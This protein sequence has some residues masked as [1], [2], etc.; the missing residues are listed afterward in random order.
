MALAETP[1]GA[2]NGVNAVFTLAEIPA[3][4]M[5]FVDRV[6]QVQSTDYSLAGN[7][8]TFAAGAI[9]QLN[10]ILVW[11]TLGSSSVVPTVGGTFVSAGEIINDAAIELGL[12]GGNITDPYSSSDQNIVLLCRLLK[13]CGRELARQHQW[14]WMQRT[15]E[16]TSVQNQST[17]PLPSDFRMMLN[18]TGWNRTNRLPL[19]GP[20]SPQEWEFLKARLAGVVFTVLFRPLNQTIVLYPDINTPGGYDIAFEYQSNAW[21]SPAGG[22]GPTQTNALLYTDIVYF[23]PNLAMLRLKAAFLEA[24]GFE[25][26]AAQNEYMLALEQAMGDDSASPILRMDGRPHLVD[27]LLDS[28]SNTPIT[29]FGQ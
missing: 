6:L 15:C 14:T 2:V 7:T 12:I 9:P 18:Q 20:M 1:T 29:G 28:P 21:A 19:G 5:L 25:S 13:K 11:Y 22:S 24:K 10:S 26:G 16:F 3:D 23:D 4:G 17:Y 27:K 8:I